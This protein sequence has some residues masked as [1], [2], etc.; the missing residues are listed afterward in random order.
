[1]LISRRF[2]FS[3]TR[4][5]RVWALMVT[6]KEFC[7]SLGVTGMTTATPFAVFPFFL[8]SFFAV[9]MADWTVPLST[10]TS[11][12]LSGVAGLVWLVVGISGLVSSGRATIV[13]P[14]PDKLLSPLPDE[15]PPFP[16]P[17]DPPLVFGFSALASETVLPIPLIAVSTKVYSV[18]FVSPFT[19]W[20]VAPASIANGEPVMSVPPCF[21]ER[22]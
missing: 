2:T 8:A 12:F 3:R 14:P 19:V 17:L 7:P 18:P 16:P 13:E 21:T 9:L 6:L 10:A 11:P 5:F 15:P 4:V 22:E 1:M 20:L